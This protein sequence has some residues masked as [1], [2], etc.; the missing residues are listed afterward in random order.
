V[1]GGINNP[2]Q[3]LAEEQA[4]EQ[5][6]EVIIE[7]QAREQEKEVM[8]EEAG[9]EWEV[10]MENASDAFAEH[11]D[12]RCDDV[13]CLDIDGQALE[14]GSANF[15]DPLLRM[16]CSQNHDHLQSKH[17]VC[18]K[19]LKQQREDDDGRGESQEH[20]GHV[21]PDGQQPMHA[22]ERLEEKP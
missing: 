15:I 3:E 6:Q 22:E 8:V 21:Q 10:E 12:V 7:E 5:E 16:E 4:E 19:P 2:Q 17:W 14:D 13:E 20:V 1:E 9:V 11:E 18:L